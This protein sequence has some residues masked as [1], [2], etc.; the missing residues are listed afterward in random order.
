MTEILGQYQAVQEHQNEAALSLKRFKWH[1][2]GLTIYGIIFSAVVI[3]G[4]GGMYFSLDNKLERLSGVEHRQSGVEDQLLSVEHRL[5]SVEHR[6]L[7]LEQQMSAGF[8]VLKAMISNLQNCV[9]S[10]AVSN[11]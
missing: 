4:I 3:I 9:E 7:V 8:A 6:L 11:H 5:L 10:I 2:I 1:H